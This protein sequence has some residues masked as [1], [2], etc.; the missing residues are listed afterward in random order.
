MIKKIYYILLFSVSIQNSLSQ[1]SNQVSEL[2]KKLDTIHYAESAHIG[3]AGKQSIIFSDYRKIDS[4]ATNKE[5][6]HFAKNGSNSLRFYSL[7]SLVMRKD[8]EKIIWLYEFYSAYPMR[9]SYQNGCEVQAVS[10]TD[11]IKNQLKLIEKIIGENR[12]DIVDKQIAFYKKELLDE[13]ITTKKK[14]Y[15]EGFIEDLYKEKENLKSLCKWN[16]KDLSEILK[17]LE[18]I[19]TTER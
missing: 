12:V 16:R 7:K 10:L 11:V 5:L 6:L 19:D 13:T 17:K 8:I 4:I 18:I 15:Y 1:V 3:F 2:S 9:V 14:I